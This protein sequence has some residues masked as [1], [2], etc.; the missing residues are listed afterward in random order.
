MVGAWQCAK[1]KLGKSLRVVPGK[2]GIFSQS[3]ET[4]LEALN[5]KGCDPIWF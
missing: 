1:H 4:S 3:N 5:S 2:N